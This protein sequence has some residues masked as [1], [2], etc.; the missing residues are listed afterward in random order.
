MEQGDG[1]AGTQASERPAD[2]WGAWPWPPKRPFLETCLQQS[3]ALGPSGGWGPYGP[4]LPLHARRGAL[5][6]LQ[7]RKQG[8]MV[9]GSKVSLLGLQP[10][11]FFKM[12]N[13][14]PFYTITLRFPP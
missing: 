12:E 11:I 1:D 9:E 7:K 2:D 3:L 13:L 8:Q 5:V 10:R 6:F 14:T 4:E